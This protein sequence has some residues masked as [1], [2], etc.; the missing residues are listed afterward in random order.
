MKRTFLKIAL[1]LIIVL[2]FAAC[3]ADELSTNNNE[4]YAGTEEVDP[5]KVIPPTGG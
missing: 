5:T 4:K 3:T 2:F 1:A